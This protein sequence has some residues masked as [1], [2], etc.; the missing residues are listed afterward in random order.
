VSG[1]HRPLPLGGSSASW[2]SRDTSRTIRAPLPHHSTA[3]C[4]D[5]ALLCSHCLE[6]IPGAPLRAA[7]RSVAFTEHGQHGDRQSFEPAFPVGPFS[8][9]YRVGV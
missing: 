4:S 5:Q 2:R 3:C 8:A 7:D 1:A 9:Q 6:R